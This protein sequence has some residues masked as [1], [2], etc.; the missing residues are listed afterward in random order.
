MCTVGVTGGDDKH[1]VRPCSDSSDHLLLTP[2]WG[3]PL[4][5]NTTFHLLC[6]CFMPPTNALWQA[7]QRQWEQKRGKGNGLQK[8]YQFTIFFLSYYSPYFSFVLSSLQSH[9]PPVG[10]RITSIPRMLSQHPRCSPA[11]LASPASPARHSAKSFL[12][13]DIFHWWRMA[14][15]LSV[16]LLRSVDKWDRCASA[17]QRLRG[18]VVGIWLVP[19]YTGWHI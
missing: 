17:E 9:F 19:S 8:W 11:S 5:F 6:H 12:F 3:F 13:M 1:C 16:S 14:T 10:L 18:A 4:S 7:S 15:H 2:I